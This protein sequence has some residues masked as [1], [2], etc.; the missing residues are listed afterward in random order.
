MRVLAAIRTNKW[1]EEEERLLA[2]LRSGFGDDVMVVYHNR[3]AMVSPPLPVVD[4]NSAW[5]LRNR[6][7]L[8][9]D[10]GWR[11]GD[12]FY[13]ALRAARPDYDAYWLIEPDVH[14]TADAAGFFR[15][16]DAAGED[17]LGHDLGP[18]SKEIRFTR[19]LP[20]MA[21]YRA[22]FALTR[23]SGRALD[24]LFALRQALSEGPVSLRDYPNDEIFAFTHAVADK[25]LVC[26][27]LEDHA[28]DWFAD[29]QF[30][31]DPDMLFDLVVK[32][33]APGRVLHPVRSRAAFKQALAR[34]L[35]ANTGILLRIGEAIEALDAR[36]IDE[37]AD[38][39]ADEIR[40]AL[41][42][43]RAQRGARRLRRS[44]GGS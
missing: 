40:R 10:W 20:D 24:R 26:G 30:A 15:C 17:V 39:A 16:F 9:P 3:G 31:P 14:F 22:I 13:Y 34:R 44:E 42:Q 21:H 11:C 5:V 32:D 43:V 25:G 28:P 41:T 23:F 27:R 8:V 29:T 7:P 36:E 33:A 19:G 2:A 6:L 37:V 38:T 35:A 1:T 12:Y 4:V 18:F